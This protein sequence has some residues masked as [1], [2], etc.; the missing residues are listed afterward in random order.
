MKLS[1]GKR[2]G[3]SSRELTTAAVFS[4]FLHIIIFAAVFF[5]LH[6]YPK[7]VP[8]IYQV[9]LVGLPSEPAKFPQAPLEA[10]QPAPPKQ[11]AKAAPKE[12]A[13]PRER[14][15]IKK[16]AM[17]ELARLPQKPTPTKPPKPEEPLKPALTK[18]AKLEEPLQK[19]PT[20]STGGTPAGTTTPGAK[21]ESVGMPTTQQDFK[22]G[23]YLALV[24]GQISQ[25]WRPPPDAPDA[26]A[27]VVFSVN[28]SGWVGDV[29]LDT[30]H[31]SGTFGFK[32]AAIRAIRSSNPFPPLPEEFSKQTLEFSVD[33]MA[34]Q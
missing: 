29:N 4:F 25:H 2:I 20:A 17:P 31:S 12:K 1:S 32:Q 15:A 14:A 6:A 26:K 30:E 7:Y 8:P 3:Q 19:P 33:L 27:R 5:Y 9:K 34:E 28:R 16:G 13:A 22:F 23:Y 11:K 10:S 21:G 24:R 18:S